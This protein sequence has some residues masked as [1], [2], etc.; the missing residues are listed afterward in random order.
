MIKAVI[1]DADGTLID[2]EAPGMDLLYEL[3]SQEGLEFTRAEAHHQFRGVRMAEVT[4]WI[5]SRLP[6]R[7]PSFEA[8]F[9]KRYRS[10][11]KDRFHRE[12]LP[13]PGAFDLL[14]RL[15]IPFC[16]ATNGPREKIEMTLQ[17]TGLR[18]FF[19]D[20]IF[21]AYDSGQFKP[22]P[23]LFLTA[24][25]ALGVAPENCAVIE[26]SIPG[27]QAGLDAGMQVF[28]LHAPAGLP[29]GM[30]AR[31]TFIRGLSELVFN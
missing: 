30:A 12:L 23:G 14:N 29:V 22:D 6:P 20:R 19:G 27:I 7:P 16:V 31:V 26:D 9:T 21:C 2:S 8:D 18:H 28:S 11:L 13:M 25:T 24:A 15:T 17:L 10:A 4:A 3:A 1:F 5:A